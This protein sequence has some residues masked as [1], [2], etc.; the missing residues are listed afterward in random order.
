MTLLFPADPRKFET[1][2]WASDGG[3]FSQSGRYLRRGSLTF[4]D[5]LRLS[6]LDVKQEGNQTFWRRWRIRTWV[7]LDSWTE[8]ICRSGSILWTRFNI[9]TL[10]SAEVKAYWLRW[11]FW[12]WRNMWVWVKPVW[13]LVLCF[14]LRF[15]R[16]ILRF[17]KKWPS[18][19]LLGWII[20]QKNLRKLSSWFPRQ[21]PMKDHLVINMLMSSE[22]SFRRY[23][24]KVTHK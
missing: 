22:T 21:Q 5:H 12:T 1:V 18:L 2:Y 23:W 9:W 14:W 10:S 19:L 8:S 13:H 6:L 4:V 17:T 11:N 16:F 3:E 7:D 24:C 20:C 15:A